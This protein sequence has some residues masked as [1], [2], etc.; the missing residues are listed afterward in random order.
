MFN[1]E[2][3]SLGFVLCLVLFCCFILSLFYFVDCVLYFESL[4]LFSLD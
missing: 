4:K 2:M 3:F 1:A